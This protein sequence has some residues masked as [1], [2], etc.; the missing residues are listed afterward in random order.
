MTT[1]NGSSDL[2]NLHPVTHVLQEITLK[3]RSTGKFKVI[4]AN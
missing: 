2:K 3:R 1:Q 4:K